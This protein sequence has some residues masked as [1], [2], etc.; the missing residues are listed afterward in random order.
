MAA[1][2]HI[3]PQVKLAFEKQTVETANNKEIGLAARGRDLLT[4]IFKGHE[5]F[6]GWTPD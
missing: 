1:S 3:A 2:L 6:L 5:E 4:K